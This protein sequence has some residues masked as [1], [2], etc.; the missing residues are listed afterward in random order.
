VIAVRDD[1]GREVVLARAARRLVSLVP[2]I[3]ETVFALGGGEALVGVSRYCTEPAGRVER[4]EQVGGTKNPD[5]ERI[6][7]LR[8]DLVLVNAEENRREDFDALDAAGVT[9]FVS[10]PRRAREVS[11]LLTRLG[12]LTGTASAAAR[13]AAELTCALEEMEVPRPRGAAR[14][15]CPIWKNPWMSFN[16]DTYADDMLHIAGGHNV[17]GDRPERYCTV[18][19]EEIAALMPEVILLPDEPYVFRAKDLAAL[20]PLSGTPASR[21]QRV[22]FV[23]GK[24]LSWYGTRT[25]A[26]LRYL[27][28]QIQR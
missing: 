5:V 4:V 1:V 7:A 8:P 16:R 28:A 20:G 15:F 27:E 21:N 6:R 12:E 24:A 14:V 13:M 3:T 2:S 9:V 18:S 17:C 22:H 25:A 26:A 10:F 11:D 23:D 19:L